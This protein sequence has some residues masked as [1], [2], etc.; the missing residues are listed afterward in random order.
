MKTGI[1]KFF[2]SESG[3]GFITADNNEGE[4]FVH[5]HGCNEPISEG[6]HVQFDT[7]KH[8]KGTRAT[9]VS[10]IP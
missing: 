1:V 9:N 5:C 2:K 4:F 3:W 8:P 7:E 6:Q 10:R